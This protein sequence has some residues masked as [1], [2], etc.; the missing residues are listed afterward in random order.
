MSYAGLPE[1]HDESRLEIAAD[2]ARLDVAKK[3]KGQANADLWWR[4]KGKKKAKCLF[5]DFA[6]AV[7][8]WKDWLLRQDLNL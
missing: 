4:E 1:G 7:S 6:A 2:F 3:W 5:V 8:D